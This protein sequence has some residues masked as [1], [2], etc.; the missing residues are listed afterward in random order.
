MQ[1]ETP[2]SPPQRHALRLQLLTDQ[3]ACP[4]RNEAS[5]AP[6]S[7]PC[8]A[9]SSSSDFSS[10]ASR[11]L[12]RD[13]GVGTTVVSPHLRRCL[14]EYDEY[15]DF[16]PESVTDVAS[17]SRSPDGA[18]QEEKEDRTLPGTKLV[19]REGLSRGN[20]KPFPFSSAVVHRRG[21][22]RPGSGALRSPLFSSFL[23]EGKGSPSRGDP[24]V[25]AGGRG[26]P[27]IKQRLSLMAKH[28]D[29]M[30][31]DVNEVLPCEV[32]C[33]AGRPRVLSAD[34][35]P[36]SHRLSRS[37]SVD[38]SLSFSRRRRAELWR[39]ADPLCGLS[40]S[41]PFH[42][43]P[44][45][46]RIPS[47]SL[48]TGAGAELK[49][50]AR[51]PGKQERQREEE[52]RLQEEKDS[53]ESTEEDGFS[54][55]DGDRETGGKTLLQPDF[56]TR[57]QAALREQEEG[58]TPGLRLLRQQEMREQG[59]NDPDPAALSHARGRDEEGR[60]ASSGRLNGGRRRGRN[61]GA[62]ASRPPHTPPSGCADADGRDSLNEG[63][64]K[65]SDGEERLAGDVEMET[66]GDHQSDWTMKPETGEDAAALVAPA[67]FREGGEA[68]ERYEKTATTSE[69]Q[70]LPEDAVIR[71]LSLSVELDI[72]GLSSGA[73][74]S[75]EDVTR[76]A[77]WREAKRDASDLANAGTNV[78]NG[79][80]AL[81]H[82][83]AEKD[84]D[85]FIPRDDKEQDDARAGE[86]EDPHGAVA[87]DYGADAPLTTAAARRP[88]GATASDRPVEDES[89]VKTDCGTGGP[90]AR[91]SSAVLRLDDVSLPL[92][93][94]GQTM[95]CSPS[96]PT[97]SPL[98]CSRFARQLV[99]SA[100][101]SP[102]AR[103]FFFGS[104]G[105]SGSSCLSSGFIPGFLTVPRAL[106]NAKNEKEVGG[107]SLTVCAFEDRKE[108]GSGE[109]TQDRVFD[110][111]AS[112]DGLVGAPGNATGKGK[113]SEGEER[114][115]RCG[116][117]PLFQKKMFPFCHEGELLLASPLAPPHPDIL[118]PRSAGNACGAPLLFG[119][120]PGGASPSRRDSSITAVSPGTLCSGPGVGGAKWAAS[121]RC[122]LPEDSLSLF[123]E[124]R[125]TLLNLLEE[126]H[127]ACCCCHS[128]SSKGPSLRS[129]PC[130]AYHFP[131]SFP[132]SASPSCSATT[133]SP[134]SPSS[135][136]PPGSVCHAFSPSAMDDA[137]VQPAETRLEGQKSICDVGAGA[138][139]RSPS[140][141]ASPGLKTLRP[142]G[143]E[144]LCPD[145]L[146]AEVS[147]SSSETV[148]SPVGTGEFFREADSRGDTT[149]SGF[150]GGD[151]STEEKA[152]NFK[153][154]EL[155]EEVGAGVEGASE[156][157]EGEEKE[158]KPLG[159][160]VSIGGSVS[161]FIE[162]GK[163]CPDIRDD[164]VDTQKKA[165][166][167]AKATTTVSTTV[168]AIT[169]ACTPTASSRFG[170]SP[171]GV[172]MANIGEPRSD[173]LTGADVE[174]KRLSGVLPSPKVDETE[175][176]AKPDLIGMGD[177]FAKADD[178]VGA[179]EKASELEG[180]DRDRLSRVA[181]GLLTG[182]KTREGF[183]EEERASVSSGATRCPGAGEKAAG[184]GGRCSVDTPAASPSS[185]V[186][187]ASPGAFSFSPFTPSGTGAESPEEKSSLST[188][189]S[190]TPLASSGYH[191]A[192]VHRMPGVVSPFAAYSSS[193][194]VSAPSVPHGG[195]LPRCGPE[196][197]ALFFEH[198][199]CLRSSRCFVEQLAYAHIFRI[200][201][202]PLGGGRP[203]SLS[204]LQQQFLVRELFLLRQE[205]NR[206]LVRNAFMWTGQPGC[207]HILD[208]LSGSAL[209]LNAGMVG[210]KHAFSGESKFGAA[211]FC[212]PHGVGSTDVSSPGLRGG[213]FGLDKS[214]GN[215]EF[216]G[217]HGCDDLRRNGT[218]P[219]Q[220]RIS[221][222][223]QTALAAATANS[224]DQAPSECLRGPD[225]GTGKD[226]PGDRRGR[227]LRDHD[228]SEEREEGVK[229]GQKGDGSGSNDTNPPFAVSPAK[230]LLDP[231]IFLCTADMEVGA[232]K[233]ALVASLRALRSLAPSW[234]SQS[235]GGFA[236]H[237]QQLLQTR[238]LHSQT[239]Q[240]YRVILQEL[241]SVPPRLWG[242]ERLLDALH[243]LD[244]LYSVS[245]RRAEERQKAREAEEL[246]A[247]LAK[248]NTGSSNKDMHR[249]DVENI[250][251]SRFSSGTSEGQEHRAAS[252]RLLQHEARLGQT[253]EGGGG[254]RCGLAEDERLSKV[255]ES[256]S[257]APEDR[258]DSRLQEKPEFLTEADDVPTVSSFFKGARRHDDSDSRDPLARHRLLSSEKDELPQFSADAVN[259]RQ[260]RGVGSPGGK[261]SSL[262][263]ADP[264]GSNRRDS[265]DLEG[266]G[267]K[268]WAS[269]AGEPETLALQQRLEEQLQRQGLSAQNVGAALAQIL[270]SGGT[271]AALKALQRL[272]SP[273]RSSQAAQPGVGGRDRSGVAERS[274]K[275]LLRQL[276]QS[277]VSSGAPSPLA[278][279]TWEANSVPTTYA[280]KLRGVGSQRGGREG[281]EQEP[282]PLLGPSRLRG[283]E[284]ASAS[285]GRSTTGM[286][287]D[288]ERVGTETTER[289]N[290]SRRGKAPYSEPSAKRIKTEGT[291]LRRHDGSL[292]AVGD[293]LHSL[294]S[295]SAT[296]LSKCSSPL[297]KELSAL[298]SQNDSALG[299]PRA[300]HRASLLSRQPQFSSS[301][302]G[303]GAAE[304]APHH[305]RSST[306][307]TGVA[308]QQRLASGQ[309]SSRRHEAREL[310]GEGR[311]KTHA[312]WSAGGSG[313]ESGVGSRGGSGPGRESAAG[314]QKE[315]QAERLE[316]ARRASQLEK[317]KGVFIGKKNTCWVAQWTDSSGRSRQTCYNIKTLGFEV[318]RQKAIEERQRQM[319][320]APVIVSG[321]GRQQ[322]SAAA[323]LRRQS[324]PSA[325]APA[326]SGVG[327]VSPGT[328][329]VNAPGFT[330]THVAST[331]RDS[332]ELISLRTAGVAG[333]EDQ[334]QGGAGRRQ[335]LSAS[336]S[337]SPSIFPADSGPP[338]LH[339][340]G[341]S[342]GSVNGT[343][344]MSNEA[345]LSAV[346][347]ATANAL[348]GVGGVSSSAEGGSIRSSLS[349]T[350]LAADILAQLES[351]SRGLP[352][353]PSDRRKGSVDLLLRSLSASPSVGPS[354]AA[355]FL[356]SAASPPSP[357]VAA[358][359][360]AT[361]G[362]MT[363][364]ENGRLPL[365]SSQG[366]ESPY[367]PASS[368]EEPGRGMAPPVERRGPSGFAHASPSAGGPHGAASPSVEAGHDPS[369]S[370]LTN[371]AIREN[372]Q[373]M[374]RVSPGEICGEAAGSTATGLHANRNVGAA[375]MTSS[376]SSCSGSSPLVASP[377]PKSG[378][379]TSSNVPSLAS[380]SAALAQA[381]PNLA[382]AL[383]S[384]N[385]G[386]I[387]RGDSLPSSVSPEQLQLF[388]QLAEQLLP[389]QQRLQSRTSHGL[390]S[391]AGGASSLSLLNS[392]VDVSGLSRS[393]PILGSVEE[394]DA[395]SG[396]GDLG[397][398]VAHAA[399][400][401]EAGGHSGIRPNASTHAFTLPLSQMST[402]NLSSLNS[403][404]SD[405]PLSRAS[406]GCSSTSVASALTSM[407]L[408]A[409]NPRL[410]PSSSPFPASSSESVSPLLLE[411][412]SASRREGGAAQPHPLSPPTK[413]PFLLGGQA[414]GATGQ[415]VDV[416][417]RQPTG[418]A[419]R[420]AED[421]YAVFSGSSGARGRRHRMAYTH[422]QGRRTYASQARDFPRV[423]GIK[424][425]V[426]CACWE[427]SCGA[428]FKVFS[429]RR[430]GGLQEAYDLAV[431]WKQE[432]E[433][434]SG[435]VGCRRL[436]SDRRL[437][438]N[439]GTDSQSMMMYLGNEG[440]GAPRVS[441]GDEDGEAYEEGDHDDTFLYPGESE[442]GNSVKRG[443]RSGSSK[444]EEEEDRLRLLQHTE[445]GAN[446][447]GEKTAVDS[448]LKSLAYDM[449][450]RSA[451][452]S[453]CEDG[454]PA[455]ALNLGEAAATQ[456]P[457]GEVDMLTSLLEQLTKS[458][459]TTGNG[460]ASSL[461]EET[462]AVPDDI[463]GALALL[464]GAVNGQSTELG[465][466]GAIGDVLA[467]DIPAQDLRRLLRSERDENARGP[468]VN[469]DVMLR[470]VKD[471]GK[472]HESVDDPSPGELR[473]SEGGPDSAQQLEEHKKRS[474]EYDGQNDPENRLINSGFAGT[475][476]SKKARM[477]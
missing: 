265:T 132:G 469:R 25:D 253:S 170:E 17:L 331:P 381:F 166:L 313:R 422:K 294:S 63:A 177:G 249:G 348:N 384:P 337:T 372:E 302:P 216:P 368:G 351:A 89:V 180:G 415:I 84:Q 251:P 344:A 128:A 109:T 475:A 398:A 300:P 33:G 454:A 267:A 207:R 325:A 186:S 220:S 467:G 38:S 287:T 237:L 317:V 152:V 199:D 182:Q 8:T 340:A 103:P 1:P 19:D 259:P 241:F 391:P 104:H 364:S 328:G 34:A 158:K 466:P 472:A 373:E 296:S 97:S 179:Q 243:D 403:F 173:S 323:D 194:A 434:G 151:S 168:S 213:Y 439:A 419:P 197:H 118:T 425:N 203:S 299:A 120:A 430:L 347:R 304:S 342:A 468:A 303:A 307:P 79:A 27:E 449:W 196:L 171:C 445:W 447:R 324:G 369:S 406:S 58:R 47:M 187:V 184:L 410:S 24:G 226:V 3:E 134:L 448:N 91:E 405:P 413:L 62:G 421:P 221:T 205:P 95:D 375:G 112:A 22:A 154:G 176:A 238:S 360:A 464:A 334:K 335:N 346:V 59:G 117:A 92:Y 93:P 235:E 167:R 126:L 387:L 122:F 45:F 250:E 143:L 114:E 423:E 189:S 148:A 305:L 276:I 285:P 385:A 416:F 29:R 446:D 362:L 10:V 316:Y 60:M 465:K 121:C 429:T 341:G 127:D 474:R 395:L 380:L 119:S 5:S 144:P 74:S 244:C 11:Q 68:G 256:A 274:Q 73:V 96:T 283:L 155:K 164:C 42:E 130:C 16:L 394:A 349:P 30:G 141:S 65:S 149:P 18:G 124:I 458:N 138:A 456:R 326:G 336:H 255:F 273:S 306:P 13:A 401:G 269:I 223:G 353:S 291:H 450:M 57:L 178:G 437:A 451:G 188:S 427:V 69:A 333:R 7:E 275:L 374:M 229:T 257:Y 234:A 208:Q 297:L 308:G 100:S 66:V 293:D 298:P 407:S 85:T 145:A 339:N 411:S 99:F 314:G 195:V 131:S 355:P 159:A 271:E 53:G 32:E 202:Q 39:A 261:P 26:Q 102:R 172:G 46:S 232:Q 14:T 70:Q 399:R 444:E 219:G 455:P 209:P 470:G 322:S 56:H 370:S 163:L 408:H 266:V 185:S 460:S 383:S 376:S 290:V 320:S 193:H 390:A 310:A 162:D 156:P 277:A 359:S 98:C 71:M 357:E 160:R 457:Q 105:A 412:T 363:G 116:T 161:A 228:D 318:A 147:P 289:G 345:L 80:V 157:R 264:S 442:A 139:L 321:G 311:G 192:S 420:A 260:G 115:E 452:S 123:L 35:F 432:V 191:P 140:P 245:K 83:A 215:S 281:D 146:A 101:R 388:Q 262:D 129:S 230:A 254:A 319:G 225:D 133:P 282:S 31:V 12:V 433:G 165:A 428:G 174:V 279:P 82:V 142:P 418:T 204:P 227:A 108:G 211:G 443:S 272:L 409:T 52:Q 236:F 61:R 6:A 288:E 41:F 441:A 242:K 175:Q 214:C 231:S 55:F 278:S 44:L 150:C 49:P 270:R 137:A 462:Q 21:A 471:R 153:R 28:D 135:A 367:S 88:G 206:L 107:E 414:Q 352:S 438:R 43:S 183:E 301:R 9:A 366:L 476:S 169:P 36:P 354:S 371:D 295:L 181:A 435:G 358:S 280:N 51:L 312:S 247:S 81:S 210:S 78:G 233:S 350:T 379:A 212:H 111:D 453:S 292:S 327:G 417:G 402:A 431:K 436:V 40:P 361:A 246:R 329:D 106:P 396:A 377:S 477:D 94:V 198:V 76:V 48:T 110:I 365:S 15:I 424:Y 463:C 332:E 136:S 190:P 284:R 397:T 459:G 378:P 252:L 50:E 440:A 258:L 77:R 67:G 2:S 217:H 248:G 90:I 224:G 268:G 240:N 218:H 4:G 309:F 400:S 263:N 330:G 54:G 20:P 75:A 315:E 239:L 461:Q 338:A 386:K 286:L 473:G 37:T 392:H 86:N 64:A 200:C 72:M 87:E 404:T 393:S 382:S 125:S 222:R 356:A 343:P 426:K 201:L 389:S 113:K 23:G